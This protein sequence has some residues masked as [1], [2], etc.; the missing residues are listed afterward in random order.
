MTMLPAVSAF[1]SPDSRWNEGGMVHKGAKAT[2]D[3]PVQSVAGR[4]VGA[5][6]QRS[7]QAEQ[8]ILQTTLQVLAESGLPGLTI[9]RVAAL[10]KVGKTTI[11]RRWPSKL[12]LVLDAI[13]TLPEVRV[14]NTGSLPGDLRQIAH[15]LDRVLHSS[16]LGRVVP[17]LIAISGWDRH[18]HESI[19]RYLEQRRAPVVEVMRMAMRRGEIPPGSD[20]EDLADLFA[21]AVLNRLFF[22]RCPLDRRF[23]EF[24]IAAVRAGAH[25]RPDAAGDAV[26]Q[27]Q[28]R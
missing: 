3:P 27:A 22:S 18:V 11:Y 4:R 9:E 15:Y 10:A 1:D 17:H 21:G 23:I 24:T 28:A 25:L 5:G 19:G 8:A 20:P 13:A 6:R 12:P 26:G 14:P 7:A 16:V 2:P